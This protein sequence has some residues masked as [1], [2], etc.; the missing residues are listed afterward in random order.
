MRSKGLACNPMTYMFV[1]SD[2]STQIL[3]QA[4]L[5]AGNQVRH[6][7]H[8]SSYMAYPQMYGAETIEYSLDATMA[9]LDFDDI[10]EK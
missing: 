7:D 3:F 5:E 9:G 2:G 4:T 8:I 1:M 6:L 10:E